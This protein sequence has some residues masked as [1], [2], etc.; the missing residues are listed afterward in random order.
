MLST[1]LM[2]GVTEELVQPVQATVKPQEGM[3]PCKKS[4]E[5]L[6]LLV[7]DINSQGY[8]YPRIFLICADPFIVEISRY[9]TSEVQRKRMEYFDEIDIRI[10]YDHVHPAPDLLA[11]IREKGQTWF[12]LTMKW[13]FAGNPT[14]SYS[15]E[16][17]G[18][19]HSD[20]A[21]SQYP[22]YRAVFDK[23]RA[24]NGARSVKSYCEFA[25]WLA[26]LNIMTDFLYEEVNSLI[27]PWL[28]TM[29]PETCHNT[30]LDMAEQR[31]GF[32][33]D[34]PATY[35][36]E[37]N[38]DEIIQGF[39][40]R[41]VSFQ[42]AMLAAVL[43]YAPN[44]CRL[45]TL[46]QWLT[47]EDCSNIA[48]RQKLFNQCYHPLC[49]FFYE[50]Y[51][52][53]S[54]IIA[55]TKSL[56]KPLKANYA[57]VFMNLPQ[58]VI[59]SPDALVS[60]GEVSSSFGRTLKCQAKNGEQVYLKIQSDSETEE[61]FVRVF[62]RLI[63]A[64]T[65]SEILELESTTV[66]PLKIFRISNPHE[67]IQSTRL[68]QHEHSRIEKLVGVSS[69][70]AMTFCCP[71]DQPYDEY[72]YDVV[73]GEEAMSG[74]LKYARDYG[75]LWSYG[76]LGPACINAYHGYEQGR[77]HTPL[78]PYINMTSEGSLERW[79]G[80][81]TNFPNV[82]GRIG[83]RDMGDILFPE[84]DIKGIEFHRGI[85]EASKDS[86]FDSNKKRL[87]E[88]AR[89]AQGIV[90]LY[91]R[92]FQSEFDYKDKTK[93]TRVQ[94][95]IGQLLSDLFSQAAPV[96]NKDCL[97]FMEQ[98][99]LLE[100]C[101]REVSYWMAKDVPYVKDL[102]SAEIN[103]LVYPHLPPQMQGA[104]LTREQGKF[105]TD[106]GFHDPERDVGN[107]CQLGAGNGRNPLIA[108]NALIVKMLSHTVLAMD[109]ATV[110]AEANE[111][112]VFVSGLQDNPE[113][114]PV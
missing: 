28:L 103:R 47:S 83:M 54:L 111:Q 6:K 94:S 40:C 12:E 5:L 56:P 38:C 39:E 52:W 48:I 70:L 88:L 81:A 50:Y 91:A 1:Q 45:A 57:Q 20:G 46:K 37:H 108:L 64:Y 42:P 75:R 11:Q 16:T 7:S 36:T 67:F 9:F 110:E 82:G 31:K 35:L 60:P 2:A 23:L 43:K 74:L 61:A 100:Q 101:A 79:N 107:E 3:D 34:A 112:S 41:N 33:P 92:R 102:R 62:Q 96:N 72:N 30:T 98:D 63:A 66:K 87:N 93:T 89:T 55:I 27:P 105:L 24:C 113:I 10:T 90:I 76:L 71:E 22:V 29:R 99:G 32:D 84:E 65:K 68:E 73:D 106:K 53:N 17:L 77:L 51:P 69:R 44:D 86:A 19:N 85:S 49:T 18:L 78:A 26:Q 25:S 114:I 58:P 97:K 13:H 80:H 104:V 59:E 95:D 8:E 4:N 14:E 109:K 21:I 15:N